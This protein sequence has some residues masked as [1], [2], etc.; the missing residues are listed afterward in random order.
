MAFF[1]EQVDKYLLDWIKSSTFDTPH[2]LDTERFHRFV[3]AMDQ[4]KPVP[5]TDSAIRENIEKA[6][7]EQHSNRD[8]KYIE[9]FA[10]ER[11]DKVTE[12]LEYL[13]FP[14]TNPLS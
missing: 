5:Y 11:A 9:E 2:P 3:Q 12:L 6:L 14:R 8:N 10:I 7:K 13:E 1:N 4:Y